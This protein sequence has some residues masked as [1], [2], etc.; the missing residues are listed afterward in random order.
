MTK[1][2]R[3]SSWLH[4]LR[5]TLGSVLNNPVALALLQTNY[6]RIWGR[7]Q[8]PRWLLCAASIEKSVVLRPRAGC[9]V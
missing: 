2:E 4:S 9:S 3:V 5:I 8:A 1:Y 7:V 6:I